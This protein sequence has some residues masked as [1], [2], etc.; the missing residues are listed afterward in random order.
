MLLVITPPRGP[1]LKNR[2]PSLPGFATAPPQKEHI[3]L[4]PSS[5]SST[6]LVE[7]QRPLSPPND[8]PGLV[9]EALVVRI[10]Q[11]VAVELLLVLPRPYFCI[12]TFP[13]KLINLSV[14]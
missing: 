10:V 11:P 13:S 4:G 2:S 7:R 14:L 9:V 3:V 12:S 6:H 5:S 8:Q 1:H